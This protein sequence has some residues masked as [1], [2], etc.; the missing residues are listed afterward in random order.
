MQNE[1]LEVEELN[2]DEICLAERII[3]K[4]CQLES[5]HFEI[6]SLMKE[7]V[8][9]K[10]SKI[11]NLTPIL[12]QESILRVNSRLDAAPAIVN[13]EMRQPI[14]LNGESPITELIIDFYHRKFHHQT[15]ETV[16][17][18]LRQRFW[19]PKIRVFVN[20][21]INRCKR[22]AY[23]KAE[24]RIPQM[25]GLPKERMAPYNPPFSYTGFDFMG[26]FQVTVGR[27]CEKRWIA[28]FTC[29]TMRAIHLEVACSLDTSS[30]VMCVRNFI[31]RRGTPLQMIS[32]NGTNLKAAEKELR[33]ALKELDRNRIM[34][35]T[36]NFEPS[37]RHINWK[38]NPPAAPHFGG[39]WERM[40][41]IVKQALYSALKSRKPRDETFRSAI[42]EVESTVNCRPLNYVSTKEINDPAITPSS[43]LT[44]STNKMPPIDPKIFNSQKQWLISQEIAH[45]F[46][47]RWLR[48]YLPTISTRSKW[49]DE[50]MPL[51]L[52][53]W[54]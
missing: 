22:C 49:Y 20:K 3:L 21:V 44:L 25:A 1:Q 43:L 32:D 34:A 5:Y 36:Q 30:A 46:W 38:F 16:I 41:R 39:I 2:G 42:I 19:I 33:Q 26:P 17:N 35:D 6:K 54:C 31:N 9:N 28:I 4:K 24:P 8:V 7:G 50:C 12:D 13:E 48:E 23:L 18:E 11:Y 40:V 45:N 10:T 29:L 52:V 47:K 53:I 14:I 15:K 37:E 27:R 51:V